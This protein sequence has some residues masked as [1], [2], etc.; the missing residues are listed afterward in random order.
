MFQSKQVVG[1]IGRSHVL[2]GVNTFLKPSARELA[3]ANAAELEKKR[4]VEDL[5]RNRDRADD[6]AKKKEEQLRLKTEQKKR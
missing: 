2:T 1:T 5:Q 4:K 3:Q 6:A